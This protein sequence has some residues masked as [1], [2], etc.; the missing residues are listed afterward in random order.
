[1][2]KTWLWFAFLREGQGGG[3]GPLLGDTVLC[4]CCKHWTPKWAPKEGKVKV[5]VIHPIQYLPTLQ[6]QNSKI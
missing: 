2:I 3:L 4:A 1:M 6:G 5:L